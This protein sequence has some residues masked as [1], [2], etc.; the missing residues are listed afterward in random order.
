M[1]STKLAPK[2]NNLKCVLIDIDN[3]LL[4][5]GKSSQLAI[6][7]TCED[8]NIVYPKQ[9]FE[10]FVKVTN[11][12]WRKIQDGNLT[13]TQLRQTRWKAIFDIF[14]ISADGPAFEEEFHRQLHDSAV[15]V[16]G[17]V[18]VLEYLHSKYTVCT[19]SNASFEQQRN[20]MELAGMSKY[21]D[22]MFV[23]ERLGAQKP[24]PAFFEAC[25]NQ[26]ILNPQNTIM[27]GDDIHADM[28]GAAS[29]GIHTCWFNPNNL[30]NT[31]NVSLDFTISN[32]S[33]LYNLL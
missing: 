17:A 24:S 1:T 32:L 30:A 6:I 11:D 4:D 8:F 26:L 23:S 2:L 3:T 31:E 20:R 22:R 7:R 16:D 29:C 12:M 13:E 33:D 27:I 25:L 5:F 21:I 15:P 18:E 10:V 19:A 28:L 14:G 9:I